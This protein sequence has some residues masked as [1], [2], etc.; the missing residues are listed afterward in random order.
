M[1]WKFEI[2]IST[3]FI[4]GQ[5]LLYRC[6]CWEVASMYLNDYYKSHKAIKHLKVF[7]NVPLIYIEEAR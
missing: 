6:T 5:T 2:L 7:K 3:Y 1:L 4:H